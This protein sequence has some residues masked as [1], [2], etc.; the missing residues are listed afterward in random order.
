MNSTL[1]FQCANRLKSMDE[2]QTILIAEDDDVSYLY[3][4]IVFGDYNYK[5][6]RAKTGQEAIDVCRTYNDIDLVLMDIKLPIVNGMDATKII[7]QFNKSIII[8]AQTAYAFSSD[9]ENAIKAGC[10]DYISKPFKRTE[11]LN[12]VQE[13]LVKT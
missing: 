1:A 8:I 7:R 4:S 2:Y 12:M 13:Y 6:V 9:R 5:L 3:L 10:N 11:L